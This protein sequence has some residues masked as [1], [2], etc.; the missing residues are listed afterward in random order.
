MLI[1]AGSGIVGR[2]LGEPAI[3]G[4]C[5]AEGLV[6][7]VVHCVIGLGHRAFVAL[8]PNLGVALPEAE[9]DL[10]R[11]PCRADKEGEVVVSF[12]QG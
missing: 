4:P 12:R 9:R 7:R 11:L 3:T 6:Q 10:P 1:V 2:F 5:A 8:V